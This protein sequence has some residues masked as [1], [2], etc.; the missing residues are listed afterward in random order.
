MGVKGGKVGMYV[1]MYGCIVSYVKVRAKAKGGKEKR[2][3]DRTGK[4]EH[5]PTGQGQ[6]R[7]RTGTGQG[8]GQD[9]TGQDKGASPAAPALKIFI[10]FV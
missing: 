10:F 6:D 3:A 8:Q 7:D 9:R 2:H 1:C 4:L 5:I